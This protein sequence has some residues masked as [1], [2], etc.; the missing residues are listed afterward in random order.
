MTYFKVGSVIESTESAETGN[1]PVWEATTMVF[2]GKPM[3]LSHP[4]YSIMSASAI[5][6]RR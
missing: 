5:I 2:T 3:I 1:S 4:L 6:H